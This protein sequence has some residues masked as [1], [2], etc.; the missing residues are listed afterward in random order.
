M[1]G[2]LIF[3]DVVF[4]TAA[5]LFLFFPN[6]VVKL[7]KLANEVLVCTDEKIFAVRKTAGIACLIMGIFL[8][9]VI[10]ILFRII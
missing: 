1:I 2:F 3:A 10:M 5:I 7:N 9:V 4:L 8:T 6:V